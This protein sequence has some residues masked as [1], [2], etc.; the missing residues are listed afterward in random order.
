MAD[1]AAPVASI[2]ATGNILTIAWTLISGSW[3]AGS[4]AVNT[5]KELSVVVDSG[6]DD[7]RT[8]G[9]ILD[10]LNSEPAIDNDV[11]T[12]DRVT[13]KAYLSGDAHGHPEYDTAFGSEAVAINI[14]EEGV[15]YDAS[16]DTAPASS[17][18]VTN[19]S[20][21]VKPKPIFCWWT[22]PKQYH[23]STTL[24]I[25]FC[26]FHKHGIDIASSAVVLTDANSDTYQATITKQTMAREGAYGPASQYSVYRARFDITGAT[27]GAAAA[28]ATVKATVA[29][30]DYITGTE[31]LPDLPVYIDLADA[32]PT[33]TAFVDSS[34]SLAV[35]DVAGGTF[36]ELTMVVG[37][38]SGA[39]AVTNPGSAGSGTLTITPFTNT[40]FQADETVTEYDLHGN[41]T[42]V[43]ATASGAETSNAS[44]SPVLGD[45]NNPYDSISDAIMAIRT[46]VNGQAGGH[47]MQCAGS[48]VYLKAGV[49]CR[50]GR[51]SSN[52]SSVDN[53]HYLFVT[54]EAGL[55]KA[56]VILTCE[57]TSVLGSGPCMRVMKHFG[58]T[59]QF[60]DSTTARK[61]YNFGSGQT[62][63][64]WIDDCEF[65]WW[66]SSASGVPTDW[67]A[68]CYNL[69]ITNTYVHDFGA[70]GS[71]NNFLQ[72]STNTLAGTFLI[73]RDLEVD[74]A[75]ADG[76]QL[77]LGG[78]PSG[79]VLLCNVSTNQLQGAF[80]GHHS[81]C[82]QTY[83]AVNNVIIY[84]WKVTKEQYQGV[85]FEGAGYAQNNIALVNIILEDID[86]T[87]MGFDGPAQFGADMDH[88]LWLNVT[89]VASTTRDGL[90]SRGWTMYTATNWSVRNCYM[91]ASAANVWDRVN[92]HPS[93]ESMVVNSHWRTGETTAGIRVDASGANLS[94]LFDDVTSDAM[95]AAAGA[96]GDDW[97]PTVGEALTGRLLTR[98]LI[99]GVDY[100]IYGTAWAVGG[101]V[102]AVNVLAG[103]PDDDAYDSNRHRQQLLR[104]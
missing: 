2:D 86:D 24:D 45:T 10:P 30:T 14:A 98:D 76:D 6:G 31:T 84:N 44:G 25:Y 12:N 35:T 88:I 34:Y 64:Q 99:D 85:Y 94:D 65:K 91:H 90:W 13:I 53:D 4:I 16:Y 89:A 28:K 22:V 49:H 103:T 101:A 42:G 74:Y 100:D 75:G 20:T 27:A 47:G 72:D 62:V 96:G 63:Y 32:F 38:T 78:N 68:Y 69:A 95:T 46:W 48:T 36:G 7:E 60:L 66:G 8:I 3:D 58:V 79:D 57:N 23:T 39:K 56:D 70:T 67:S 5:A 104:P 41:A 87:D 71:N 73:L 17:G 59:I 21:A 55:D 43:T 40:E 52:S 54:R 26:A 37:G 15:V 102:G 19:N 82:F 51:G 50:N 83:R 33:T 77:Y 61:F 92:W 97:I 11:G 1:T 29:G 80:A 18:A 93:L 9:A 81:D